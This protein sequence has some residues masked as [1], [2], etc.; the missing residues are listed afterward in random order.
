M[1][2]G[3]IKKYR[4]KSF[5]DLDVNNL[6]KIEKRVSWNSSWHAN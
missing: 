6:G 4:S 3:S 2:I 1:A 5:L